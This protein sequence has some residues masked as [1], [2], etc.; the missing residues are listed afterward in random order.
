MFTHL[1]SNQVAEPV[2]K[3]PGIIFDARTGW[4]VFDIGLLRPQGWMAAHSRQIAGHSEVWVDFEELHASGWAEVISERPCASIASGPGRVVTAT[5]THAND[6]VR[7]LTLDGGE[8]LYVT[9]NHRMYSASAG[10]W[11]A[12]KDLGVGEELQTS[13]GR[14][15]VA[16]LGYQQGRH[17]VYNIEVEAEHCYF[18]GEGQTLTHNGCETG[19]TDSAKNVVD[20]NGYRTPDGKF[21]SPTGD[22]PR[23]GAEAEQ[24]VWDAIKEKKG[25]DGWTVIEGQVSVRNKDGQ[26]RKYDGA[27][28]SPRGRVIGLEVKSGSARKTADQRNFE[29]SLSRSNVA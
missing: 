5:I 11:V 6:D 12:V 26:L 10:D 2:S 4:D 25:K 28:V 24:Q 16:A 22:A 20:K 18:V 3:M 9:G 29:S 27:A 1:M 15:S 17:Q 7:T 14:K 8:T 19:V 23:S 21:A 13:S